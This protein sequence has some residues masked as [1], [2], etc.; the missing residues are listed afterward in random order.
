MIMENSTNDGHNRLLNKV[1]AGSF[2]SRKNAEERVDFLRLKGIQSF[3]HNTTIS[4]SVWYRVQAGAFSNRQNAEKRLEEVKKSGIQDAFITSF[5]DTSSSENAPGYH[6]LGETVLT[7]EQM[8]H[9]VKKINPLAIQLGSYYIAFGKDYGI[10]GDIAF[11]QALHE[12][13]F[14][15]FTG[16]V[17]PDQN[18]FSGIGAT[19]GEVRG[20]RF[21][22]PEEGVLAHFQ[23]LYAYASTKP[24]PGKHPLVDPRFHLVTRGSAKTWSDL[25]GKWAVPGDS[26]GESIIDLYRRM[27]KETR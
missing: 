25:N 22:S 15:R 17:Q 13:D 1:I 6:I 27:S 16:A 4:G 23:H 14:F 10:R 9:F 26:Y 21:S 18:N 7:A 8:N 5:R 2:K 3:I 20:A 12:T 11:A 24:L 19:G